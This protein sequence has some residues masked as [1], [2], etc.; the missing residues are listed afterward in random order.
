MDVCLNLTQIIIS[1]IGL[2]GV[3]SFITVKVV[4]SKSKKVTQNR[5]SI[6]G[7]GDIVGGNKTTN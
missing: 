7:G 2:I 3:S 1:A 4:N 5:N 6:T